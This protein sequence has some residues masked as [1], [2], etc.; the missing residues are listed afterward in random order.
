MRSPLLTIALAS[1][2]LALGVGVCPAHLV[3]E[4]QVLGFNGR[5]AP[6]GEDGSEEY[7]DVWAEGDYAYLGSVG[8]GV[9]VLNLDTGAYTSGALKNPEFVTAYAP[10]GHLDYQD[11]KVLDGIGYFSGGA[12]ADLV[13]LSI[14]AAPTL[15]ARIDAALGGFPAVKNAAVGGGYLYQVSASSPEIRVFDVG[16]PASPSL[17]RSINT[18][19][20]AGLLDV[21]L[22]NNRLYAAGAGGGAYVYDVSNVAT[23]NPAL[24]LAVPTGDNTASVW[25]TQDGQTLLVTHR[26]PGGKLAAW[27]VSATPGLIDQKSAGDFS[28]NARS[29]AEVVVVGSLAYVA[30]HQAGIQVID[31]DSLDQVGMQRLAEYAILG[32]YSPQDY[33]GVRSVHPF[34]GPDQVLVSNTRRGLWRF[35]ATQLANPI[36]GDYNSDGRVDQADFETW[37]ANYGGSYAPADGNGDGVVDSIDFAVWRQAYSPAAAGPAFYAAPSPS[38]AWLVVAGGLCT[39]TIVRRRPQS[40]PPC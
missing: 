12:G 7:T 8:S 6:F 40:S 30:W 33:A 35:D 5:A 15:L 22:I 10:A 32:N 3:E 4:V 13:D 17:V 39:F 1:C 11:V 2:L 18:Q 34:L 27:D 38:A 29:T 23:Q 20:A 25:P 37:L 16:N 24:T 31:I 19:D 9:A 26:E 36:T 14:P 21:T 28:L